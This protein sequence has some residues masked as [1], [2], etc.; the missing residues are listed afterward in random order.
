MLQV[1]TCNEDKKYSK[2]AFKIRE[3]RAIFELQINTEQIPKTSTK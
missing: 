3:F 1:G 2:K